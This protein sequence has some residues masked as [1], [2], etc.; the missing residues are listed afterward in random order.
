MI[1][2]GVMTLNKDVKVEAMKGSQV[3]AIY[4]NEGGGSTSIGRGDWRRDAGVAR[5][6]VVGKV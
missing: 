4:H 5:R 3:P 2:H 6:M 1:C